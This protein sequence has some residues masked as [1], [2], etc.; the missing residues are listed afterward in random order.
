MSLYQRG[1]SWYIDI[2]IKGHRIN[3]KA[4]DTKQEALELQQALK[5]A[6]KSKDKFTVQ[7]Y[8]PFTKTA[9]EYLRHIKD[10]LSDRSYELDFGDYHKHLV[11]FFEPYFLADIS[12]SLLMQFQ[13]QQ[14]KK[15]LANRTVN[16][17]IGLVRKIMKYAEMSGFVGD[18][19]LKYPMLRESKKLHA[20]LSKDEIHKMMEHITDPLTQKRFRFAFLTGLRPKEL[21]FLEWTDIDMKA[22]YLK[23]QNKPNLSFQIKTDEERIVP[24]NQDAM[25]ILKDIKR[26][27]KFLFSTT[28]KPVLSIRRAL[29]TASKNAKLKRITPNMTRHTFITHAL[30]EGADIQAVQAIAGHKDIKTTHRYTHALQDSMKKAASLVR[31]K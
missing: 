30:K 23:I 1:K 28:D 14:K 26:V 12:N 29:R 2:Q 31:E 25:K 15:G 4:G 9:E 5:E 8:I 20:Y 11:S 22:C 21:S 10:T 3:R 19:H 13:R 18:L 6:I 17:H 7:G 24:L 16:I 27:S